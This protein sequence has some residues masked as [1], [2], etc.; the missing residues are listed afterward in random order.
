MGDGE[1]TDVGHVT[2]D[3]EHEDTSS[4]AGAGIDH[5]SDQSIAIAIVVELVVRSQG[6]Q[7]SRTNTF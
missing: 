1:I 3:G 2:Q 5:T 7:S 4:E 6:W